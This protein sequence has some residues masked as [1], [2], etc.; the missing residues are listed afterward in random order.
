MFKKIYR[1][2]PWPDQDQPR[3]CCT[4]NKTLVYSNGSKIDPFFN[5]IFQIAKNK[6]AFRII[7]EFKFAKTGKIIIPEDSQS[8]WVYN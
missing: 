4:L 5:K 8:Q 3:C 6:S 7:I 1:K 2:D